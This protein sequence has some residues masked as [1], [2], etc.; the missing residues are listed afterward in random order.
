MGA[1]AIGLGRAWELLGA[2]RT[3]VIT[4][5]LETLARRLDRRPKP[6]S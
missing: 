3:G 1:Y 6:K 4:G 5:V 2:P